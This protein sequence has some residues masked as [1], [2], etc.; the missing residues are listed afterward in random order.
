[1]YWFIAFYMFYGRRLDTPYKIIT[2][3]AFTGAIGNTA[4]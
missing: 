3:L 1:M 4:T 2:N